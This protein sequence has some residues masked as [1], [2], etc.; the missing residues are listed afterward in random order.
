MPAGSGTTRLHPVRGVLNRIFL[1]EHTEYRVLH[2]K[3]GEFMVLAPRQSERDSG[4][5]EIGDL[6]AAGWRPDAA[7]IIAAT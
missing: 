7:R 6:V 1:G 4:I 5:Y 3:L 2:E